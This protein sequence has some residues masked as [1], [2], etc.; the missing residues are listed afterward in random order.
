MLAVSV[1][2]A[3][4][5]A[6]APT[7]APAQ[8]NSEQR[9]VDRNNPGAARSQTDQQVTLTGCVAREGSSDFV[10]ESAVATGTSGNSST[11]VPGSTSTAA[12]GTS[13]S[14]SSSTSAATAATTKY[15]LSGERDLVEYVG[16]RVEIVGR[17]DAKVDAKAG[18]SSAP[19]DSSRGA[20][21]SAPGAAS[22]TST[23]MQHVTITS[24]RAV[25]GSCL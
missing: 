8:G 17:M 18:A 20:A 22:A 11:A 2:A 14:A 23:P 10:L 5:S 6:Q 15:R 13:G 16:Q 9:P 24:V 4:G 19:S 1:A 7:Q 25:G 21:A 3:Q 12:V